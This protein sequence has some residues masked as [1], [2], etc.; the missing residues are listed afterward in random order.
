MV[1]A[2]AGIT[3]TPDSEIE[4]P[5][6]E[7]EEV[8][9]SLLLASDAVGGRLA[10]DMSVVRRLEYIASTSVE[11]SGPLEVVQYRGGILPLLRV[12]DRLPNGEPAA[13]ESE[14]LQTV[15]CASSIGLVGVVVSRIEDV[16]PHP[17]ERVSPQ[18]PSRRGIVASFVVDDRITELIDVELLVADAGVGSNA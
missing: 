4:S 1:G 15:V 13:P 9:S 18:P 12:A 11:R 8:L 7:P 14:I 16:A 3:A 2:R 5:L 17:A 10:I 6:D